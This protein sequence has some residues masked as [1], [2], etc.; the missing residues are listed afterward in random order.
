MTGL[1]D[2]QA[3]CTSDQNDVVPLL[4]GIW[5]ELE[6]LYAH[7]EVGTPDSTAEREGDVC[8]TC[9]RDEDLLLAVLGLLSVR[10]T[11]HRWLNQCEPEAC[12]FERRSDKA[13]VE[14]DLLR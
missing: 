2:S 1:L 8:T 14:T 5:K 13:K 4:L 11:L 7:V 10:R 12:R 3:D 9:V 6:D